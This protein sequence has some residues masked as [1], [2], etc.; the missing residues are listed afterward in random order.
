MTLKKLAE[1][2]MLPKSEIIHFDGNPLRYYISM[3]HFENHVEKDT[4]DNGRRLQYCSDKAKKVVE[5]CVLLSEGE[6]Y[7]E[8]KWLLEERFGSKY[9]Y[10][11]SINKVSNSP[12]VKPSDREALIDLADDLQNCEITL[13]AI[14]FIK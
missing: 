9:K 6:G 2:R 11:Y 8:A 12:S 7:Y 5:S 13:R 10:L 3:K 4:D 14:G 1:S